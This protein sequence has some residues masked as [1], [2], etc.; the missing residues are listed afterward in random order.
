M[1]RMNRLL[2]TLLSIWLILLQTDDLRGQQILTGSTMGAGGAGTVIG[3]G[4]ETIYT[5]PANLIDG[6]PGRHQYRRMVSLMAGGIQF[7]SP[8]PIGSAGELRTT[9]NEWIRGYIPG[10]S[11]RYPLQ[12]DDH[13]SRNFPHASNPSSHQVRGEWHWFGLQW[14]R[15]NRSY[16]VGLRSR[17]ANRL[18]TGR[19][20][21][22]GSP[23]QVGELSVLDRSSTTYFH[24]LHELSFGFA[25]PVTFLN[26]LLP[27]LSQ[28]V[29][30][31]APKL[32]IGGSYQSTAWRDR[33]T[34]SEPTAPWNRTR[35][36]TSYTTGPF[37][38]QHQQYLTGGTHIPGRKELF[39]QGGWGAGLDVGL[40]WVS[41]LGRDFSWIE[42]D[43]PPSSTLQ[44]SVS[45]L[46]IGMIYY[47][48]HPVQRTIDEWSTAEETLPDPAD[49]IFMGR[50]G[51]QLPFYLDLGTDP[52]DGS[53]TD[54]SNLLVLLPSTIQTGVAWRHH[55]WT[56]SGDL[57]IGL[58]ND[59][60]NTSRLLGFLGVEY[61]VRPK[62]PFRLA[63]RLS[64][65]QSDYLS[66]GTGWIG[67]RLDFSFTV[68]LRS[69]WGVP[70]SEL[71]GWSV[72]ALRWKLPTSQ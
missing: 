23:V 64:K 29:I 65:Y 21:Y 18:T 25:E 1:I 45:F 27:G 69:Q 55:D 13:L 6:Y 10:R 8:A 40:N 59:A 5:N 48:D 50:P 39:G 67:D 24:A 14:D 66:I 61:R 56:V 11:T 44:I 30:G 20:L 72:G 43:Q 12:A 51:E 32:V 15:G 37:S 49:Q 62:I 9:L 16:A 70:K 71:S 36:L 28:F 2:F 35:S 34:R 3:G 4:Y 22:D 33:F 52:L 26:G 41:P 46:D 17:F 57:A 7:D 31:I 58:T 42:S 19:G 47:R 54:T 60:F 53:G 68:Q 38:R 63:T